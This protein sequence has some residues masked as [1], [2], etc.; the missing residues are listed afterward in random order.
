MGPK[1]I[2]SKLPKSAASARAT[3]VELTREGAP[4]DR[5]WLLA[6]DI[7][8]SGEPTLLLAGGTDGGLEALTPMLLAIEG[9][10][11][12]GGG[13]FLDEEGYTLCWSVIAAT[14]CI[15]YLHIDAVSI[16]SRK[17]VMR[18]SRVVVESVRNIRVSLRRIVTESV[19]SESNY[20]ELRS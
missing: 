6:G 15:R 5:E 20:C 2:L 7:A 11:G 16:H 17:S 8:R 14:K 3:P 9:S 13:G 10:A 4:E 18:R 19:K 1:F 12:T